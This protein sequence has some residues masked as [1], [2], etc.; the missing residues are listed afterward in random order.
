[1]RGRARPGHRRDGRAGYGRTPGAAVVEALDPVSDTFNRANETPLSTTTS[2]H[3]WMAFSGTG[4]SVVSNQCTKVT[5]GVQGSVVDF[6]SADGVASWG[7]V[8]N[9]LDSNND[10][11]LMRAA[12]TSN[13]LGLRWA[14]GALLQVVAGATTTLGTMSG[15]AP[16][17]GDTI[18]VTLDGGSVVVRRNGVSALATTTALL[19]G[20]RFGAQIGSPDP[21]VLDGFSVEPL[22]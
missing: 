2:G 15:G 3:P 14:T 18:E 13:Y 21:G 17:D 19:T 8:A 4:L 11:L 22:P 7:I 5:V 20:S 16:A 10:L 9:P 6:G 1:M 12:N